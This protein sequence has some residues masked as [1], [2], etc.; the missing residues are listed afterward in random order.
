MNIET[1]YLEKLKTEKTFADIYTDSFE[2][3]I[4]G[5]IFDFNEEFLLLE[6]FTDIGKADGI[7]IIKRENISRIKWAGNDIETASHFALKEK[8]NEKI[9]KL[10]I[11]SIQNILKSVQ[12]AFGYVNLNIQHIDNGMCII[13]EIEEMDEETVIIKEYG[14]YTSLDRK[15]LMLNISEIT[16][17]E[18]GGQYEQNLHELF[19][20]KN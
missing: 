4:Y 14:T 18:G 7:A 9:G 5:F 15:M 19:N 10:K 1:K 3:S 12:S 6:Q 11:D 13:G 8:Q 17:V 2:E 20:K 16:K